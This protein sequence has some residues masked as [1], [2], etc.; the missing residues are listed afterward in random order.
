MLHEKNCK[1]NGCNVEFVWVNTESIVLAATSTAVL[2]ILEKLTLLPI[3]E[4]LNI[5]KTIT[6]EESNNQLNG[7]C[8]C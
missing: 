7:S 1:G 2:I 8:D 5:S 6:K 4:I 3:A